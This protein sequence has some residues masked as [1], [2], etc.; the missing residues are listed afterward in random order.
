MLAP[1]VKTIQ[2]GRP[3]QRPDTKV[4]YVGTPAVIME[5]MRRTGQLGRLSVSLSREVDK[6]RGSNPLCLGTPNWSEMTWRYDMTGFE[7]DGW[8]TETDGDDV[9]EQIYFISNPALGL[10]AVCSVEEGPDYA[11]A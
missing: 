2:Q 5:A 8:N 1:F 9:E 4:G 6:D 10:W 3:Y 11:S 7:G